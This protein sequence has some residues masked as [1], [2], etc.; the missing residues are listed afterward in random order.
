MTMT[1]AWTLI[2]TAVVALPAMAQER[3]RFEG[4]LDSQMLGALRPILAQ[5]AGD[6][7][8]TGALED[9]A[10]E[11]AAKGVPAARIIAAVRQLAGELRDARGLLRDGRPAARIPDAEVIAAA[12]TR[13]RGVPAQEIAALARGAS[14]HP[15]VVP[16]TVLGDLV[17]RGVPADYARTVLEQLLADGLPPDR[18]AEIPGRVDVALRVGAAPADALRSA[19]RGGGREMPHGPPPGGGRGPAAGR[20]IQ[21]PPDPPKGG[22]PPSSGRPHGNSS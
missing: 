16:L 2:L 14:Q 18:M 7:L 1:R 17:Q 19:L 9:K 6:S 4:R 5:A 12:E 13:R 21:P 3:G 11:G 15:L 8:P 20:P 22:K 10:L